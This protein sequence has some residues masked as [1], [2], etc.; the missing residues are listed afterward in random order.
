MTQTKSSKTPA[1]PDRSNYAIASTAFGLI[2]IACAFLP[3]FTLGIILG[4]SGLVYAFVA[5]NSR[6]RLFAQLGGV[7][8]LAGLVANLLA[9]GYI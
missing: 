4:L 2:S 3:M 1:P 7:L 5:R 8:G 9:A 6:R